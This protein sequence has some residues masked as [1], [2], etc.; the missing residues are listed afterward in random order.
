MLRRYLK[1]HGWNRLLRG[2]GRYA[3]CDPQEAEYRKIVASLPT[4]GEIFLP[5]DR[6]DPEARLR[7]IRTVRDI[8]RERLN[9]T[10]R[11]RLENLRDKY[12]GTKRCFI[13]GNGPSL[14]R[15]DLSVLKDEV[16]FAV[17][18]F[19]LKT[20]DLDWLPTFYVV[21]DHLVAED[22][23]QR[24]NEFKGPT[25]LFPVYL[26]Y[27]LE[28]GEDTIF[29]NHQ[30]RKSYPHGFDFSTSAAEITYS[31]CT[32]TFTC[33]QLAFYLGFEEVYLIGVDAS[34]DLPKDVERGDDYNVGVLDMKSD[35]PNHFHPDYFGKGFRWH[36]PQVDK[37]VDAYKEARRVTDMTSQRIY[38]ATV[39]GQLEV[40]ER[41]AFSTL[42]PDARRRDE[43]V[44]GSERKSV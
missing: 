15:T 36:D 25:K 9:T 20:E 11:P 10:Y 40:F 8:Y 38:N 14:N 5:T 27:C 17:N 19:F 6:F 37:M 29:F 18:G 7:G 23:Q 44:A 26:A 33:M 32:V 21:E 39:G 16:T 13:I 43:A 28:E 4:S 34:Y 31:G 1:R 22:R 41:R 24:I 2:A 3:C 42:F 35:D 30:P 12:A